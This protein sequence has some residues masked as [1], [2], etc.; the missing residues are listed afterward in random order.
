MSVAAASTTSRIATLEE[1][2][3]AVA[4]AQ[5]LVEVGGGEDDASAVVAPLEELRPHPRRRL[6][7][8]AAGRVLHQQQADVWRQHRQQQ[9]LLVAAGQ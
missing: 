1:H 2:G 8:E 6:D 9:P 5:Q 4:V 3:D 7:V